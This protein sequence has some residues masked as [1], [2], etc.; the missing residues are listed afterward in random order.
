[1]KDEKVTKTKLY[2]FDEIKDAVGRA[3]AKAIE[4][5]LEDG[6]VDAAK[7]VLVETM[8]GAKIMTE[9]DLMHDEG[10]L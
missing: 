9:L 8:V 5:T 6:D 2:T 7:I 1:M 4:R 10:E 3:S